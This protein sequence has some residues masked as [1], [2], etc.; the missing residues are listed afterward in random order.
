MGYQWQAFGEPLAFVKTQA[1][2]RV[3]RSSSVFEKFLVLA[4][5]KPVWGAFVPS[6]EEYWRNH[7]IYSNPFASSS[8]MNPL[9][10]FAALVVF[11]IGLW[12]RWL[13]W[14][15]TLMAFF[16]LLIPYI[17]SYETYMTSMGRYVAVIFPLYLVLGQ[18]LA[19]LRGPLAA[20]LLCVSAGFLTLYAAL[21]AARYPFF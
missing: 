6:C 15:E 18:M 7:T 16:L 10:F 20:L 3:L 12:R 5:L 19:R 14:Y 11:A 4:T 13:S 21:F 8:L 9:L 2:W 1:H 17:N